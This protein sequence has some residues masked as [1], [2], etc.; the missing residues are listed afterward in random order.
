MAKKKPNMD[1]L[2]DMLHFEIDSGCD[3]TGHELSIKGKTVEMEFSQMEPFP[4]HKFRLYEGQ[5]L[6]D[7]VDSIRQF[8]ILLPIILWHREDGRYFILSGH[9]RCNA[10]RMAGLK[11][12][13]VIIKEKLTYEDAVLIV[14]E[15]NL[16]QRSFSDLSH[17]E[18]AYCLAQHYE[19][20]K[21]QGKR[22][23]LLTEIETF[24]NPQDSGQNPTNAQ[25]EH[26]LNS[27][28]KIGKEYGLSHAKVARYIRIANSEESLIRKVDSGEIAL[29]AAYQLSF[30]ED[31]K[32]QEKMARLLESKDFKMD[33]KKAEM[34]RRYYEEDRLTDLAIKEILSGVK[35]GEQKN[36]SYQTVKVK[37]EVITRYFQD[38]QSEKEIQAIIER[39]IIFYFKNQEESLPW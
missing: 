15:T 25:R 9:N 28:D 20:M 32:L 31:K 1:E 13:P 24:M 37:P 34:L 22:N 21:A 14:T 18:R 10:A 12:G 4:E 30:V 33:M 23:D 29:L 7:M 38:G 36:K 35:S 2:S 39:A 11:K 5:Q 8:G 16:R 6:T 3:L 26:R 19:A 27:R 17:S